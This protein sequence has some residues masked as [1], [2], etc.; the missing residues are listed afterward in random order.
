LVFRKKPNQELCEEQN[1]VRQQIQSSQ[2]DRA[3]VYNTSEVH[4]NSA[5]NFQ[6]KY[7]NNI[8]TAPTHQSLDDFSGD[9]LQQ[10]VKNNE[11]TLIKP[12]SSL[13]DVMTQIAP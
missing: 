8:S 12:L 11:V 9:H 5:A 3:S 10:N 7:S 6:P 13:S 2:L 4:D 1:A